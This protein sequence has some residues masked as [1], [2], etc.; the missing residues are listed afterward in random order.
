MQYELFPRARHKYKLLSLAS[1]SNGNCYYLGTSEYGILI[2]AGI[3]VRTIRKYLREYGVAIETI[4]GVLV[5]HDH[6]DHIKS[7]SAL[8]NKLHIPIYTT[9]S[10]HQGISRSRYCPE[11]LNGSARIIQKN[12]PFAIRDIEITAFEVPHD[13]IQNVGYQLKINDQTIVL[14]TDIGRVTEEI[15][16]Y[17]RTANHLI[18]E[19]NYDENMLRFGRYPEILKKRISSGNGHLSN[20]LTGELLTKI[21]HERLNEI[22]LCHL[23]QDNNH[24]EV[25]YNTV[26]D[27]LHEK[28]ILV[29]KHVT[30]RTLM[31][32]KP[33][34]LKEFE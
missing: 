32:G 28:G 27:K 33:S 19:A 3:G 18:I 23:S 17:T 26:K 22:W 5:T 8:G 7:V 20:S 2:D 14:A 31:R 15:I 21:F 1:G 16:N 6:A 13:S 12:K 10:V 34:C 24:P 4:M 30:L 25:A 9:R 11:Q 29:D